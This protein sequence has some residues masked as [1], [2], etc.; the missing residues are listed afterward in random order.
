M[1]TKHHI[2]NIHSHIEPST[3]A[4]LANRTSTF[5]RPKSIALLD[6]E[7]DTDDDTWSNEDAAAEEGNQNI[8]N[9]MQTFTVP[10]AYLAARENTRIYPY[11]EQVHATVHANVLLRRCTPRRPPGTATES[12]TVTEGRLVM[13]EEEEEDCCSDESVIHVRP[14]GEEEDVSSSDHPP[15]FVVASRAQRKARVSSNTTATTASRNNGV[16]G[17]TGDVRHQIQ[18]NVSSTWN[19]LAARFLVP[20]VRSHHNNDSSFEQLATAA[21]ILVSESEDNASLMERMM[22]EEEP[23]PLER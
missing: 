3:L 21:S 4:T 6:D 22:K 9:T 17:C 15:P 1:Y 8:R 7:R 23:P 12:G 20:S 2:H 19:V 18:R 16:C 10:P 5:Y 11:T 14:L 13:Y